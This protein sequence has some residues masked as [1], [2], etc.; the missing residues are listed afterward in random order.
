MSKA[1]TVTLTLCLGASLIALAADGKGYPGGGCNAPGGIISSGRTLNPT[2]SSLSAI[3]PIINDSI[4]L[5]IVD[6]SP[7]V[8]FIDLNT[9]GAVSCTIYERTQTSSSAS[10][11]SSAG[12][13]PSGAGNSSTYTSSSPTK[14][15]FNGSLGAYDIRN[16]ATWNYMNCTIPAA[17]GNNQSGIV[18]YYLEENT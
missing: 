18:A 14:M 16:Q 11:Y 8:W 2:A 15:T 7:I 9:S 1:R 10:G 12:Q 17:S 5:D 13:Y 4:S 6:T 3:C